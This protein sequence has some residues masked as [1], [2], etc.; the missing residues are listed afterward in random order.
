MNRAP[1]PL[2][3]TEPQFVEKWS[4]V[5]N[6]EANC[7]LSDPADRHKGDYWDHVA[8]DPEHRLGVAVIPEART[9]AKPVAIGDRPGDNTAAVPRP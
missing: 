1:S 8:Y 7:D 2:L 9:D 5:A 4:F 6:K 3:T